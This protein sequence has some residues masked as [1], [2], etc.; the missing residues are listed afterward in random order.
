MTLKCSICGRFAKIVDVC[1]PFGTYEDVEPPDAVLFC[2]N[3]I[4][5]LKKQYLT[6]KY[7]PNYWIKPDWTYEIA[8]QL[9]YIEIQYKGCAWSFWRKKDQQLEYNMIIVERNY[10]YSNS[11]I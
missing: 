5:K 8:K 4:D 7:V 6:M 11:S 2:Q 1:V 9:G 3:C 10:D